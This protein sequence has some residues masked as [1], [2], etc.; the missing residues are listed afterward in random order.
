MT[1]EEIKL[2]LCKLRSVKGDDGKWTN[3][4]GDVFQEAFTYLCQK[5]G[6][7]VKES[8]EA[9]DAV[10]H[11]DYWVYGVG[12]RIPVDVK[13][14]KHKNGVHDDFPMEIL[15]ELLNVNGYKGW[16]RG[17]SKYIIFGYDGHPDFYFL[18]YDREALL[19]YVESLNKDTITRNDRQDEFLWITPPKEGLLKKIKCN[20]YVQ[21]ALEHNGY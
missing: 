20:K 21:K 3:P 5:N 19:A 15:V 4:I 2:R 6:R 18:V 12:D 11:I 9:E 7:V 1:Y 14:P 16:L 8:S 17:D 13:A 10:D